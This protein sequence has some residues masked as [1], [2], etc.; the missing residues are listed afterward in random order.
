MSNGEYLVM[1]TLAWSL[2]AWS[3]LLLP[4]QGRWAEKYREAERSL[5]RTEVSTFC[6]AMI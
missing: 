1:A 6:V 3:A 5:L 2:K 4:E